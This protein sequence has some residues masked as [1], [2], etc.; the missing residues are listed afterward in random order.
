MSL[1]NVLRKA[2][3]LKYGKVSRLGSAV[4]GGFKEGGKGATA[5]GLA[6]VVA[7]RSPARKNKIK[8]ENK[9]FL[10]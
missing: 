8:I 1:K 2:M 5:P 4:T 7:R 3:T 6:L 10:F 9:I